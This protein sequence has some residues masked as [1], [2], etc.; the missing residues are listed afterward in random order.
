M[1][2]ILSVEQMKRADD[3]TINKLGV[4]T[5]ELV[6]RAGSAVAEEIRRRLKGGRVLV[7][8]G[9]GN[10]GADGKVVAN[11]LSKI[12]GFTVMT[13]NVSNGIFKLFDKK[14]DVIVDCIFGTGLSKPVEGCI[15]RHSKRFKCRLRYTYGNSRKSK[16]YSCQSRI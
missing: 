13:L 10:N 9:K 11:I 1:E 4:G 15:L 16:P 7:C 5:D 6:W 2:R 14:Y 12:H 8:I 3:F